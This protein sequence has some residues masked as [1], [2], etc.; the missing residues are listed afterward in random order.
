MNDMARIVAGNI[1]MIG[2]MPRY[3]ALVGLL[4]CTLPAEARGARDPRESSAAAAISAAQLRREPIRFELDVPYAGT[5]N[6]RQRLDIYLPKVRTRAKLPVVVYFHGGGWMQ[7]DKSDGFRSLMPYVRTGRYAG[8]SVG[9][10]L[11]GE[12]RWPAQLHD[13]KA[14][15]RWIRANADR[16]GLDANAIGV[17]GHSAGGHIALMVGVTGDVRE[18]EG[19]VGPHRS[20]SSRVHAVANSFGVTDIL[21]LIG[22]PGAVDR[23]KPDAP[24]AFLLGGPVPQNAEKA[25]SA[26]PITYVTRDDP[27]IFM[28]HGTADRVVPYDQAL[29]MDAALRRAGV[30]SYFV[31]IEGAGHGDFGTIADRRVTAFFEKTLRGRRVQ[32]RV[33]NI[34]WRKP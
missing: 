24:E 11:S 15:I 28:M 10:R 21:A 19:D 4:A 6:P 2:S 14:A 17:W 8:I 18:L 5:A 12:A 20:A 16:L 34:K 7:R 27:P 25:K 32:V 30:P 3:M 29:R 26:S 33:S 22:Q 9:Y 1:F 31:T 23:T 13:A